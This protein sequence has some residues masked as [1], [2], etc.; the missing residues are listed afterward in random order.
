VLDADTQTQLEDLL[1]EFWNDR[2][3]PEDAQEEY[4][5]NHRSAN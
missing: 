5:R 1:V 4:A 3:T 2:H